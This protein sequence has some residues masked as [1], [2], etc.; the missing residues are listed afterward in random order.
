MLPDGVVFIGPL[1]RLVAFSRNCPRLAIRKI[2]TADIARAVWRRVWN[3]LR[4]KPWR[5]CPLGRTEPFPV[6]PRLGPL[7]DYGVTTTVTF[8]VV[9]RAPSCATHRKTYSPGVLKVAWV[10]H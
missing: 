3:V 2:G 10:S 9:I 5:L 6:D 4:V 7:D 1:G 8:S